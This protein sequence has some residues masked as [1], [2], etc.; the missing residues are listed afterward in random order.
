MKL[1]ELLASALPDSLLHETHLDRKLR[2]ILILR[3]HEHS[4]DAFDLHAR[5]CWLVTSSNPFVPNRLTLRI[6]WNAAT[7]VQTAI[8]AGAGIVISMRGD[9]KPGRARHSFSD[10]SSRGIGIPQSQ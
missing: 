1:V 9:L 10:C 4:R 2:V 8:I 7:Y 5:N 3:R 6:Q